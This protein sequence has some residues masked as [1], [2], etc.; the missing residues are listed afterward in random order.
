MKVVIWGAG[1]RAKRLFYHL[2]EEMVI[3]FVDQDKNRIG[4]TYLNK[5]I[6]SIDTYIKSYSNF[7]IIISFIGENEAIR[8]LQDRGINNYFLLSDCPAEFQEPSP[9]NILKNYVMEMLEGNKNY[10]VL[11]Y[12]VYLSVYL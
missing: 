6:I 4:S 2:E 1:V 12:N 11:G 5:E 3:A 10:A 7:P 8:I 9:K